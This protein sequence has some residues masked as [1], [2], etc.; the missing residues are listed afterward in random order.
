[1]EV[2]PPE[3]KGSLSKDFSCD[4]ILCGDLK[5]VTN[6]SVFAIQLDLRACAREVEGT[7]AQVAEHIHNYL[8]DKLVNNRMKATREVK[9]TAPTAPAVATEIYQHLDEKLV[10]NRMK[11]THV[12]FFDEAQALLKP[13][14]NLQAFFFRCIRTWLRKKR[15]DTTVIAVFSGTT[16]ALSN[17]SISTDA[18]DDDLVKIS[19]SRDGDDASM[20]PRGSRTFD[21]FFT[22]TTM[23]VLKPTNN[24][25]TN[26]EYEKSIPYGRPLFAKM[27]EKR[28]L[29]GKI[30]SILDRLLLGATQA[31][32]VGG[33]MIESRLS[34][35]ATRVQ[36]GS[37]RIDVVSKLVAKGYANLTGVTANFATFVYMPDPVCARLAMCMMDETWV[38][39]PRQGMS[40]QWWSEAVKMLYSTGLCIPEKGNVGEIL[41]ALY[42]LFRCDECRK[43]I[44]DNTNYTTFSVPLEKWIS[45]II[46]KKSISRSAR[47][48]KLDPPEIRVNFIQVCRDY[49]RSPWSG[50]ADQVFLKN[51][52]DAGTAFYTYPGCELIDFVVPTVIT[53]NDQNP[54]YSAVLVSIKSRLY[55]GPKPAE[56]LCEQL[57]DEADKHGLKSALCV[58]CVFGQLS[59]SKNANNWNA[60]CLNDLGDGHNVATVLRIPRNDSFGLTNI[61]LEMTAVSQKSELL[62]SHSFLR[63]R[64][65]K[66][67][68]SDAL[69][70]DNDCETV[71]DFEELNIDLE[72][73]NLQSQVP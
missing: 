44:K 25:S 23:A 66:L 41:T 2:I 17:Y 64:G 56:N 70:Y 62:S 13:R 46:D 5:G 69:R 52:Y 26:S 20:Y 16:S 6:K 37:T 45:A 36:M 71:K 63:A 47:K 60:D 9:G 33:E 50:V 12:F 18:Y 30:G 65:Q 28:V 54:T 49:M 67:D 48:R 19:P 24:S 73:E 8:D 61:F 22:L 21:P 55:F 10:N 72:K 14:F 29:E 27:H 38:S 57:K 31:Q 3:G 11:A 68:A 40:K 51:L 59:A 35:L 7:A 32:L 15:N 34:V 58:V 1:V 42:F 4:L 43:C 53:R 39:E